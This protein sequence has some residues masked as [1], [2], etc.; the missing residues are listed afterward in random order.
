M[1]KYIF[2]VRISLDFSACAMWNQGPVDAANVLRS[3]LLLSLLLAGSEKK[4][5]RKI[6]QSVSI[7]WILLM[8][9]ARETLN[10]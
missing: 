5:E 2:K 10:S 7:N 8:C 9:I 3:F 4:K 1:V 6:I